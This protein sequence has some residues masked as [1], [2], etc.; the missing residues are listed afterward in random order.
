[1]FRRVI[2]RSLQKLCCGVKITATHVDV[3]G[4][5]EAL[6]A[7]RVEARRGCEVAQRAV[8]LA[9]IAEDRP[10]HEP[11]IDA[12]RPSL[13]RHVDGCHRR[14][15]TPTDPHDV[16]LGQQQVVPPRRGDQPFFDQR[17]AICDVTILGEDDRQSGAH[18]AIVR[19]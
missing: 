4:Q 17:Q 6:E 13:D 10:A 14:F 3:R 18:F 9:P 1:L 19:A 16:D 7:L 12:I 11:R 5:R 15:L 8:E 2:E